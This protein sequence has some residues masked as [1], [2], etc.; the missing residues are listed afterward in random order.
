VSG[1]RAVNSDKGFGFLAP[2]GGAEDVFVHHSE[3]QGGGFRSLD[4][5]QRVRFEVNQGP[6]LKALRQSE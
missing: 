6:K 2:D 5:N 3:I 4:E 1:A